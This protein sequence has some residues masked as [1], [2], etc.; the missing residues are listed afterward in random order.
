VLR[1]PVRARTTVAGLALLIT[2]GLLTACDKPLP[3]LT[4]FSGSTAKKVEAQPVC[5]TA[6]TP[7]SPNS[8]KITEL[9]A[10][11]GGQI[12]VDVPKKL[13]SAGWLVTAFTV[14]TAGKSTPIN[15][16]GS[17]PVNGDHS[18]RLNVPITTGG[19]FLEVYPI[20]KNDKVLSTWLVS[21]KITQ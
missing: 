9:T 15:G 6:A 1:I 21:V 18:V 2:A 11:S 19:Y 8:G 4:V 10:K 3:T 5:V 20:K 16:A 13:A 14:D 7:C 17:S 12:L